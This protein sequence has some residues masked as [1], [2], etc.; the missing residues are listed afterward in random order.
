MEDIQRHKGLLHAIVFH[1]AHHGSEIAD[2]LDAGFFSVGTVEQS[3]GANYPAVSLTNTGR[4]AL[5]A[6]RMANVEPV[7][8]HAYAP[9][10]MHMGD[11]AV[12]GHLQGSPLHSP[13]RIKERAQDGRL[14]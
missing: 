5:A 6:R 11:C 13:F 14:L 8:P 12:C 4:E 1:I 7:E 3:N 2:L 10:T 9:S